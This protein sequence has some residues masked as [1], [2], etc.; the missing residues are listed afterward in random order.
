MSLNNDFDPNGTDLHVVRYKFWA[1]FD[2]KLTCFAIFSLTVLLSLTVYLATEKIYLTFVVFG[3]LIGSVIPLFLP[4][5]FEITANGIARWTLGYRQDILWSEI[6]SFVLQEEGILL[7]PNSVRYPLDAFHG[8]FIPIPKKYR[9]IAQR[10]FLYY[11]EKNI[12]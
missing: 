12:L 9:I 2:R 8:I 5:Q 7:L 1:L 4:M 10:R 3:L 11:M 6:R